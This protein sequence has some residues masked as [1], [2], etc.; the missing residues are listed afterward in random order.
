MVIVTHLENA[1]R[2]GMSKQQLL[3]ELN[4]ICRGSRVFFVECVTEQ[5][6]DVRQH[7]REQLHGLFQRLNLDLALQDSDSDDPPSP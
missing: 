3:A 1:T 6:P 5:N 4:S 7:T 2:M